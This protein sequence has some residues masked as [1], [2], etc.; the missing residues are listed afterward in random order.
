[1][2]KNNLRIIAAISAVFAAAFAIMLVVNFAV[3]SSS[4][5]LTA[6][7]L[8]TLKTLN[9]DVQGNEQL[10]AQIRELDLL[11]RRAYFIRTSQLEAG[12]IILI[13]MSLVL[14][15]SLVLL[16]SKYKSL[17][18]KEVDVIDE[19]AQKTLA[20]K[21]VR[22]GSVAVL[23]LAVIFGV[24]TRFNISDKKE[25]KTQEVVAEATEEVIPENVEEAAAEAVEETTTEEAPS[26]TTAQAER[27]KV[28]TAKAAE[29]PATVEVS[30]VTANNLRGNNANGV[31]AAKNIP[32]EWSV[33][34]GTNILWK[35]DTKKSGF[36]S[37]II[38]GNKVF[39][40]G[41]DEGS[42]ELYCYD[43]TTGALLWTAAADNISGSP[44]TLPEVSED[45][46]LAA[47]SPATNGKQVC[48]IFATGD[49]IC[50][51]YSGKRLWAKNLGAPD[52]T[53]GYASSLLCVG[54]TVYVQY[55]NESNRKVL[56]LDMATGS[57]RWSANRQTADKIA[58]SSPIM[59][60]INGKS[61][62]IVMGLPNITS[63]NPATGAENWK[64]SCFSGEVAASPSYS[65]GI[66]FG[67]S[68]YAKLVALDAASGKQLWEQSEFMPDVS[69]SLAVNGFLFLATGYGAVAAY[70]AKTGESIFTQDFGGQFYASPMYA[71]G[72][73]YLFD[74]DGMAYIFEASKEI[75]LLNS[76]ATGL[77]ASSTPAFTDGKMVVRT[78]G[79]LYCV[80]KK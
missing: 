39:I 53:Y 17:P 22:W 70:D 46:G 65:N 52:N 16:N 40:T 30:K 61:S 32:T 62:L 18:Q 2:N 29:T 34:K 73:I 36:S 19:W 78:A 54:S 42:R 59:A 23:A 14:V 37:P 67:A 27:V 4:A 9:Y 63:Y 55:D 74:T 69:S 21:Y 7:I 60:N 13:S 3:T 11:S 72:K 26:A 33:E 79:K 28:D 48:A 44:A 68:E 8:E 71:D 50:T 38:S 45:T 64:T 35:I 49:I 51:D 5:P 77:S 20:R 58:W 12:I 57:E 10:V 1:M 47:S 66:V 41:A 75:K 15:V 56:A 6:P 31:S 80:G 24:A 76:F 43:L 25:T